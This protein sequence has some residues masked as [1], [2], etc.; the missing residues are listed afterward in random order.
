MYGVLDDRRREDYLVLDKC[1]TLG[2]FKSL[3]S[4]DETTIRLYHDTE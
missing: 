2:S 1:Y 3:G 4:K